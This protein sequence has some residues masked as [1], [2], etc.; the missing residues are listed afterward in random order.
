MN[1]IKALWDARSSDSSLDNA[2]VNSPDVWQRWLEIEVLKKVLPLN[3]RVIDI[4]C[5]AGFATKQIAPI[6]TEILGIDYS[7]GMIERALQDSAGMP[8]NAGFAVADLFALSPAQFGRFEVALTVR[9]LINLPDWGAQQE[10]LS[11][12]ATIVKSGGLYIFI[13]GC[14]E[15]RAR[16][17]ML[18]QVVGLKPMP[19]VWHN[20]DFERERTLSFL[21]RDFT[22]ERDMGFGTYDLISRVVHPLLVAPEA[23]KYQSPI[24]EVAARV[25]L[26]RLYDTECSRVAVYCLRRR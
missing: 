9:C 23:P 22:L 12:I 8:M 25:A 18:R 10:A 24:N 7:H 1:A 20:V 13:E 26:E 17:N 6:V 5:G 2:Q 15:G 3:S 21:E 4:G 11:R 16:L 19:D 14:A